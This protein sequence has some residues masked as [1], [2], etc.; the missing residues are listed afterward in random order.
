MS[1]K[2]HEFKAVD[3]EKAVFYNIEIKADGQTWEIEKRYSELRATHD[4]LKTVLGFLPAFPN[5]TLVKRK[6]PK[7]IQKRIKRL[8][9]YFTALVAR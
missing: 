8:E 5:K 7:S 3:G 9:K 4:Y 2:G 1:I 6:D